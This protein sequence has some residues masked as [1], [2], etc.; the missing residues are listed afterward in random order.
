MEIVVRAAVIYVFLW[1][2]TRILGRATL[3]ELS[4]FQ[5]VLFIVMGDLVQQGVTQQDYSVTGAVLAISTIAV[6]TW[7]LAYANRR[8]RWARPITHGTPVRVVRDGEIDL[9]ALRAEQLSAEDLFAA[10]REHGI[11]RLADVELAVL[12]A[13]GKVSFFTVTTS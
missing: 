11:K 8:W 3:G 6:I 1:A 4:T 2:I 5:L 13:D 9:E 10:A 12:E 7:S